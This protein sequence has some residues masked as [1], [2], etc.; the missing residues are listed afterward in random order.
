MMVIVEIISAGL[1]ISLINKYILNNEIIDQCMREQEES[2]SE[3]SHVVAG[4]SV[5]S[6]VHHVHM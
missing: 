5:S 3:V 4:V 1:M 6:C 2:Y